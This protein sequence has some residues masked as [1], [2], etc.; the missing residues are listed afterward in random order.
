[1][2][3]EKLMLL[4]AM[5]AMVVSIGSYA[6]AQVAEE[7][8]VP[9]PSVPEPSV[10]EP[11]VP[12][13]SVPEPAEEESAVPEPVAEEPLAEASCQEVFRNEQAELAEVGVY[14]TSV[15]EEARACEDSGVANP[16]PAPYFYDAD[17]LLYT[18]DP[19]RDL[20]ITSYDEAAGV[21]YVYDLATKAFYTLPG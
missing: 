9:E 11:S 3:I 1:M 10:P 21:Y 13:P 20:Y 2:K 7:P 8:S 5:L 15:S 16:Y 19:L 4:M 6:V 14:P 18:L 12:E 17:G